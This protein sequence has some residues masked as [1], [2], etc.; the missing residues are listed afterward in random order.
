MEKGLSLKSILL[1]TAL[2]SALL[3]LCLF[4]LSIQSV[5]Q[6]VLLFSISICFALVLRFVLNKKTTIER[7][8][9]IF[10][11]LFSLFSTALLTK[12][13]RIFIPTHFDL[14]SLFSLSFAVAFFSLV[15]LITQEVAIRLLQQIVPWA[16]HHTTSSRTRSLIPDLACLEDGRLCDLVRTGLLDSQ[17]IVPHALVEQIKHMLEDENELVRERARQA[18][19]SC[20]RLELSGIHPVKHKQLDAFFDHGM[21]DGLMNYAKAIKG[22]ILSNDSAIKSMAKEEHG[23]VPVVFIEAVASAFKPAT[24]KGQQFS[25]KIQRLGKEPKQGIGYL[26]DRTMVVVNGGGDYL[27]RQVKIQVLSQKY[28]ASGKII[29]CNLLEEEPL[30]DSEQTSLSDDF[31]EVSR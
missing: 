19:E 28:S 3:L 24:P 2:S 6:A 8:G 16:D 23:D 31:Q 4:P 20:R 15:F 11:F 13:I 21:I 12:A 29:F 5:G 27:G 30:Y 9:L 25:I 17:L 26:D 18:Y 1:C 14:L 22:T 7:I 10:S